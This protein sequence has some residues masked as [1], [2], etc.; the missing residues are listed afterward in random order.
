MRRLEALLTKLG[1]KSD[2]FS[3]PSRH[4]RRKRKTKKKNNKKAT[5][6]DDEGA[7]NEDAEDDD[8]DDDDDDAEASV[9]LQS[10]SCTEGCSGV[11]PLQR[12]AHMQSF[13]IA[14]EYLLLAATSLQTVDPDET[15]DLKTLH[16]RLNQLLLDDDEADSEDNIQADDDGGDGDGHIVP[17]TQV[18]ESDDALDSEKV[19]W[20]VVRTRPRLPLFPIVHPNFDDVERGRRTC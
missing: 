13:P 12:E 16:R 5:A 17:F 8:E 9:P 7:L 18:C 14:E 10:R 1:E 20:L 2:V 6:A 19:R 15:L 3:P 4:R 11:Y